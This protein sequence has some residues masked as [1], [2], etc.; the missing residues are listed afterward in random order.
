MALRSY[1]VVSSGAGWVFNED[2]MLLIRLGV[3]AGLLSGD[4]DLVADAYWR[5]HTDMETKTADRAKGTHPDG[6]LIA[7]GGML[8]NGDHGND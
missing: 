4:H 1:N 6:S 2:L 7:Y 8:Y 3:D 5:S